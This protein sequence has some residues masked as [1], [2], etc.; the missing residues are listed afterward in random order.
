M[1]TKN[2]EMIRDMFHEDPTQVDNLDKIGFEIGMA[3]QEYETG[4]GTRFGKAYCYLKSADILF[5]ISEESFNSIAEKLSRLKEIKKR[6]EGFEKG[7]RKE[8]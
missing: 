5:P 6:G 8:R 1:I 3:K 7:N 4:A 2:N